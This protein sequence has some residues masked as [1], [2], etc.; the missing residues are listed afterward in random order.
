MQSDERYDD[1]TELFA[2]QDEAL[3]SE[4]F[5]KAVMQPAPKRSRWRTPLLFGAGGLGLGAALSQLG[6]VWGAISVETPDVDLS[7]IDLGAAQMSLDVSS[8]FVI[9]VIV[10]V[11]GCAAIMATERA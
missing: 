4:A 6:D 11:F 9:G 8:F 3:Q 2:A 5:V 1:L 10:L 7:L